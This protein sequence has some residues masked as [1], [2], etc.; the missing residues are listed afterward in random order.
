MFRNYV[1][2]ALRNIWKRKTF[3]SVY[4]LGLGIA[5]GVA[6]LLSATAVHELTFDGFN[7]LADHTYLVYFEEHRPEGMEQSDNMPIP[8]APALEKEMG[9]VASVTRVA[10]GDVL[11]R[12]GDKEL[13]LDVTYTDPSFFQTFTFPALA[14]NTASALQSRSSAVITRET[15]KKLFGEEAVA[16]RTVSL[17]Q[18]G[19]WESFVISAVLETLPDNSSLEFDM[20]LNFVNYP[21]YREDLNTWGN[22]N[23]NA[24]VRL[25]DHVQAAQFEKNSQAL[26]NKY[27]ANDIANL[28]RDGAKPDASGRYLKLRLVPLEDLHFTRFSSLG[29]NVSRVYPWSLVILSVFILFIACTNFINLSLATSFIRSREIG[30]RK[31]L[32]ASRS[33]LVAQLWGEAFLISVFALG[34]GIVLARMFLPL[35]STLL[36]TDIDLSLLLTPGV[37]SVFL[38]AF[39]ATTLI[40]GGYPAWIIAKFNTIRTLKGSLMIGSKNR[41][42]NT[43]TVIQF[44]IA[45]SLI[46]STLIVGFQIDYLRNK[47]LGFN[48]NEVISLPIGNGINGQQALDRMRVALAGSPGV[49]SI[50]GTDNNFGRGLDGSTHTSIVGFDYKNKEV[51]SHWLRI[52]YDYLKTL[53]IR[54][55]EGR[56]VS[57]QFSTDTLSV[58]INEKM[59]AALGEKN[60]VGTLLPVEEGTDFKVVGVVK[61]YNFKS[62][63]KEIMPLTM[64]LFPQ[65]ELRYIFVK[66][67][68]QSLSTSIDLVQDTWKK[69]YPAS[70]SRASFVNEN[71]DRQYRKEESM[72]KIF[73]SGAVITIFISCMGL[74]AIALL[75][76]GQRM[77]EIGIR[78]VLGASVSEVV[79]LLLSGFVKLIVIAF[80]IATPIA[81][82]MMTKFLQDFA[83]RITIQWWMLLAGGLIVLVIAVLT[84]SVNTVRAALANPVRSL[85][86][87]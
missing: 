35:L 56:D 68:P 27:F 46:T 45:I 16:G 3:S 50:T 31:T 23:H 39:L 42:R 83:Y 29:G 60:P 36:R 84:V 32:G 58:L 2:I 38:L 41:L 61:D 81:W 20:L 54:L 9:E 80:V 64:T 87:D 48:K 53:D 70:Q 30:L 13:E 18:A 72:A 77:K 69:L 52:D 25:K 19:R 43:L 26:V 78:K 65:N 22:Q 47:P 7:K 85:R 76:M 74:F 59:A 79:G 11:T 24:F 67:K 44:I 33:Q 82:F 55:L 49:V 75:V 62:L 14:G 4:I 5:F 66:V 40:A 71:T 63:H 28:K 8:L 15:A 34:L 17:N 37:L 1:K 6:L 51:K 86:S 12:Q 10:S 73:M 57:R 21:P